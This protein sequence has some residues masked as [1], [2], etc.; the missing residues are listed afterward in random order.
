LPSTASC[1]TEGASA[2]SCAST[3]GSTGAGGASVCTTTCH[4]TKAND[5]GPKLLM[6]IEQ[7]AK[8]VLE[9]ESKITGR[10]KAIDPATIMGIAQ[11]IIDLIT[12][13][14]EQKTAPQQMQAMCA[15]PNFRTNTIVLRSV[16]RNTEN[17]TP[18]YV[19]KVRRDALITTCANAE[20]DDLEDVVN[21]VETT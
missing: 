9:S 18:L 17:G 20:L 1:C 12:R 13:C 10:Q 14:R 6:N 11:I 19:R 2:E 4:P 3:E 15:K 5:F 16:N 21:D 7:A 8:L